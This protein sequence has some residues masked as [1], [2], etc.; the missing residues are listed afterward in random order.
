MTETNK[1]DN[2]LTDLGTGP[3]NLLIFFISFYCM[4]LVPSQFISGVYLAPAINYTCLPPEENESVI[5]VSED[6]CSY[7]RMTEARAEVEEECTEWDFDT[8]VFS[9]TLTSEFSLVCERKYLQA[10]YQS[11][12]VIGTFCSPI[13]GGY[14]ADRYGRK[15]VVVITQVL[16][17]FF[18]ITIAFLNNM[19]AIMTARVLLGLFNLLTLTVYTL[20][21][22]EPKRRALLGMLL[23]LPW[24]LGTMAWGGTAFLIRDW[25]WLQLVVSLPLLI[26]LPVL[27]FM[28][29]SPRWLI[30]RG[31]HDQAVQVL[32]KAA[33]W[34]RVTLQPEAD[35]RVLMNEIQES[36]TCS[37]TPANTDTNTKKFRLTWPKLLSTRAIRIITVVVCI[38]YFAVS[39]VFDG[40]NLSGDDYISD[41]F[42]YM[43]LSGMIEIPGYLL[44]TPI[45]DRWG[46]RLP[47]V[48]SF[49]LC[50]VAIAVI[51]VIPPELQ[52][53]RVSLALVGKWCISG[54]YQVLYLYASEL[55][56]TEVRMQGIGVASVSSQLASTFVPFITS[57]LGSALPWLPSFIF[58][59]AAAVA[60]MFT[61]A[62][63]DTKD[64]PLPDTIAD[65]SAA[66][67]KEAVVFN[68][69][70]LSTITSSTIFSITTASAPDVEKKGDVPPEAKG[71]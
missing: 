1:F 50:G 6:S 71:Q 30:V 34:N 15:V 21:S 70:S 49:L 37:S 52:V 64:V 26:I 18:A 28:D 59:I 45:I 16:T 62:L 61:M 10:L 47:T 35:L 19:V 17:A 53:L 46:R 24:A 65:L 55:F 48:L 63:R 69:D 42:L 27:F 67:I 9:N 57:L 44:A 25:R 51:V 4:L 8:S 54:V 23:G 58:G 14:L 56:P 33:R 39:F 40:L 36:A 12:Y 29:E 38:D 3:W 13:L 60:G 43:T 31:R 5:I 66:A 11:A 32:R 7:T 20:E 41:P 22:C 68:R 2:L